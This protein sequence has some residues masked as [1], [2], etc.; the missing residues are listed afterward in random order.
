MLNQTAGF[1]TQAKLWRRCNWKLNFPVWTATGNWR[2][3]TH[4]THFFV[5]WPHLYV[6]ANIDNWVR[7][8]FASSS[9]CHH[10]IIY[11]KFNLDTMYP[12]LYVREAWHYK[13][14]NIQLIRRPMEMN[15]IG[16]KGFLNTS[17]DEK[18]NIF[19]S[20]I[21]DILSNVIQHEFVDSLWF[22]KKVWTLIQN[23]KNGT[24]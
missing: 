15:S 14:G 23:N 2:I 17:I 3:S 16:K 1:V 11:A 22:N 24:F 19:D 8:L 20:T 6:T 4:I 18:L 9:N 7:S 13:I 5:Y 21:L 10:Q 12:P